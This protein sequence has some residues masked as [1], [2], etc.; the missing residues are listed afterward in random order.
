MTRAMDEIVW[1]VDPQHDSLAGFMDY[2]SVYAEDFLRT[3]GVLCRIDVPLDLPS[4]TMDAEVRY[5]LFLALKETLNN[6][7][8]HA[9]ATKVQ[10]TL[11]LGQ[12]QIILVVQDDGRGFKATKPAA[13]DTR[14]LTGHGLIN[15]EQRLGSIGGSYDISSDPEQGT[16]VELSARVPG[17]TSPIVATSQAG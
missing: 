12:D 11:R 6:I 17:A 10:L 15:L 13:D 8:K 9:S 14:L 16:R 5:N 1:A 3:A 7:V 4:L 2:A